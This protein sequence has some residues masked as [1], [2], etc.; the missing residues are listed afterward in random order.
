MYMIDVKKFIT[1]F[2]ILAVGT[3]TA[4]MIASTVGSASGNTSDSSATA[5][6]TTGT[7]HPAA[8]A[9]AGNAFAPTT[10]NPTDVILTSANNTNDPNNLTDVF[11]NA[12]LNEL[13]ATN[14]SGAQTD[15]NGNPTLSQPSM[16]NVLQQFESS[17]TVNSLQ[18]PDWDAEAAAIPITII[19]NSPTAFA[20]YGSALTDILNKNLISSGMQNV[21]NQ[22]AD[23]SSLP[24]LHDNIK[25]ALRD[26][27]GL[28]TPAAGVNFQKSLVKILVYD[29]NSIDLFNGTSSDPLK[30]AVVFQAE[31]NN[32]QL[33]LNEFQTAVQQA[34]AANLFSFQNQQGNGALSFLKTIFGIPVAH[35]FVVGVNIPV[36]DLITEANTS[37]RAADGLVQLHTILLKYLKNI[38]IQIAKNGL[39]LIMQNTVYKWINGNGAPHFIQQWGTTL[40]NTFEARALASL[41]NQ[42]ACVNPAYAPQLRLL[43]M[44]PASGGSAQGAGGNN[45][46]ANSFTFNLATNNLFSQGGFAAFTS[47]FQ[48]DNNPWTAML[49]IQ[50][51]EL[52]DA[53]QAQ[54]AEQAKAIANQGFQGSSACPG[55]QSVYTSPQGKF[56]P[57]GMHAVCQYA[58]GN[59]V[60]ASVI[61]TGQPEFTC[62]NKGMTYTITNAP[63]NGLCADGSEPKDTSPGQ[64]DSKALSAAIASN[65]KL[66]S[67][68]NDTSAFIQ[69]FF[70]SLLT[71]L[72]DSLANESINSATSLIK[73]ELTR[74]ANLPPATIAM[75]ISCDAQQTN[76]TDPSTYTFTAS[77]GEVD[78]SNGQAM[79]GSFVWSLNGTTIASGTPA[80]Y[81]FNASGTYVVTLTNAAA[82][83]ET[84]TCQ[85]ITIP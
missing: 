67:S 13:M 17:S 42:F 48:P 45:V 23:P 56:S 40:A 10:N 78:N 30:S 15:S 26:I 59:T 41:N 27:S 60:Q 31:Q 83:G 51:K 57:S 29:K 44:P 36:Q 8:D 66:V 71:S 69:Q 47:L 1:G 4:A 11:A 72:L 21:L 63:N 50:D 18:I 76:P 25:T 58:N 61:N 70:T 39:V 22:T 65:F 49:D 77:G 82:S 54:Q 20:D 28:K 16:D 46:C 68:A 35:A 5:P 52:A 12:Y 81:T 80:T 73:T 85:S 74:E 34:V 6:A 62:P 64:T 7:A 2:L 3:G 37:K 79:P 55:D 33:A 43:L 75:P 14:P 38:A 9:I 24:Y 19:P 84:A 32:Y 53:G